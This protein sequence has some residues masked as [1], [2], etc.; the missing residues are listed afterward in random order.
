MGNALA[1]STLESLVLEATVSLKCQT[2]NNTLYVWEASAVDNANKQFQSF[3]TLANGVKN[4]TI[5]P[6]ALLPGYHYI[7]F[8]AEM[9]GQE[10][11]RGYDFGFI[12]IIYPELVPKVNGPSSFVKGSGSLTLDGIGSFDPDLSGPSRH[13]GL[14]YTWFCRR[15]N[16]DFSKMPSFPVDVSLGGPRN[17]G[18]CFGY[19]PGRL[20]AKTK[21]LTLDPA[22]I[23]AK[24]HYVIELVV[25]KEERRSRAAIH[26]LFIISALQFSFK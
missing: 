17:K 16:E 26:R 13:D 18:G 15:E 24:L 25:S 23:K 21:E 2:T 11:T 20:S 19:G 8:K 9:I 6:R 14:S 22:V 4:T 5:E 3:T 1:I 12:R 10:G 7:R